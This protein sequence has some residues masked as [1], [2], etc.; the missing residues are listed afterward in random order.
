MKNKFTRGTGL[1]ETFLAVKRASVAESLIPADMER[2]RILDIGC[3]CDPFFLKKTAFNEKY[4]IDKG[5]GNT[6]SGIK[7]SR[8]DIGPEMRLPFD[9]DYFDAVTALALI[10]HL[11]RR[12][13]DRVFEEV[14]RTTKPGGV[15][16][17]T[18]PAGWTDGLLRIM[19]AVNLVSRQEVEEHVTRFSDADIN[20]LFKKWDFK[21]IVTGSFEIGMNL[22]GSGRKR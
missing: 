11:E 13:I 12:C 19:S 9:D 8:I 6:F 16:I 1:L 20:A 14:K 21:E 18:T 10:E 17:V 4:A 7:Y 2:S 5:P 3:G 15:F 22:Y